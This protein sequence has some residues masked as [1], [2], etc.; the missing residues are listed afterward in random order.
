MDCET[1]MEIPPCGWRTGF[2]ARFA[3]GPM[4]A[5]CKGKAKAKSQ[6]AKV[7]SDSIHSVCALWTM[8]SGFRMAMREQGLRQQHFLLC[9]A[10]CICLP[11]GSLQKWARMREVSRSLGRDR[12]ECPLRA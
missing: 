1:G 12:G 9:L 10:F 2:P 11:G 4:R 3:S 6:K 7:K 8:G 5:W